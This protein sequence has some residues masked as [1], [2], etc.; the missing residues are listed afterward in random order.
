M[1]ILI[2]YLPEKYFFLVRF[3]NDRTLNYK[4][5]KVEPILSNSIIIN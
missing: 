4:T 5:G 1:L 2:V 3:Q